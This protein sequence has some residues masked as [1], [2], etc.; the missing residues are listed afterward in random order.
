[1]YGESI[2][3]RPLDSLEHFMAESHQRLNGD[4]LD[5]LEACA[6]NAPDIAV[7][8]AKFDRGLR[9]HL[10]AEERFVFPAFV[11][12]DRDAAL[13]LLREHG[14]IR[15]QLLELGVAVD[16]HLLRAEASQAFMVALR[17]HAAREEALMYRWADKQLEYTLVEAVRLY[18]SRH[19]T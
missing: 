7:A 3:K 14:E 9:A 17:A 2:R 19:S 16:L 15:E 5:V 6:A 18:L 13:G 12:V 4:A 11:R 8:W 10:E 1:M